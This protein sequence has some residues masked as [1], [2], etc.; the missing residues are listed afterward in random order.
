VGETDW[1]LDLVT[2]LAVCVAGRAEHFRVRGYRREKP[3]IPFE[4]IAKPRL[5][6]TQ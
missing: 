5:S 4:R 3:A 6:R 1:E 2:T